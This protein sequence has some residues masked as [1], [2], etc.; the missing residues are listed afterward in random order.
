MTRILITGGNGGLG[1][2]LVPRL[3]KAG[4]TVRVMSRSARPAHLPTDTEWAQADLETDAGLREAVSG[5]EAIIHAASSPFN[6]EKQVDIEGT[7]RLLE[8]A[9][10]ASANHFVHVSIVGIERI[11]WSY[12]QSKV[13]AEA[14][15]RSGGLPYSILRATQFHSLIDY[16]L[17]AIRNLPI[18]FIP[19][20][21]KFQTIETGEVA[22]R[23]A[24]IVGETPAGLL[25]DMGGPEV[26]TMRAMAETWLA[27]QGKRCRLFRLPGFGAVARGF[28]NGYNTCPDHRDGKMTWAEWVKLGL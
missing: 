20:D 2:K 25:P 9:R 3:Q 12:Y 24:Q 19:T 11:P 27:A 26:L 16:R 22:D 23:L 8:I 18:A 28:R 1:R 13:A 14:V 21:Y 6:R 15:V 17:Q 10:R 4:Y 5:V 7:R